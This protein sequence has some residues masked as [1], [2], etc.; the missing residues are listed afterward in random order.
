MDPPRLFLAERSLCL[1]CDRLDPSSVVCGTCPSSTIMSQSLHPLSLPLPPRRFRQ[2]HMHLLTTPPFSATPL[3]PTR[4]KRLHSYDWQLRS[5]F[6]Y[7]R[8]PS[9]CEVELADSSSI[10]H[11]GKRPLSPTSPWSPSFTIIATEARHTLGDAPYYM[12]DT[13]SARLLRSG[14]WLW[15]EPCCQPIPHRAARAPHTLTLLPLSAS[16]TILPAHPISPRRVEMGLWVLTSTAQ[17]F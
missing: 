8:Q 10:D 16:T 1:R 12:V 2:L 6:I 14:G 7:F 15:G 3:H 9:I 11:T 5:N 4:L 17:L 13:S